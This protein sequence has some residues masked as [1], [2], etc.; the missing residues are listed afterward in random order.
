MK[1]SLVRQVFPRSHGK[2][3]NRNYCQNSP[4]KNNIFK[5]I[6][7]KY[8]NIWKNNKGLIVG[9]PLITFTPFFVGKIYDCHEMKKNEKLE[10][11][12]III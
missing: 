3:F 8:G 10:K 9:L 5:Q 4:N 11:K 1:K 2:L 12:N 6:S 7:I